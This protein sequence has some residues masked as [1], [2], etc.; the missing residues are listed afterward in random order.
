MRRVG[1]VGVVVEGASHHRAGPGD[2]IGQRRALEFVGF[3]PRFQILHFS[4][5]PLGDPVGEKAVLR[6]IGDTSNAAEI[7]ADFG[8]KTFEMVLQV[9]NDGHWWAR[10][11]YTG[12]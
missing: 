2:G 8:G 6:R 12:E 9:G 4:G 5:A 10:T 7:K 3:I 11:D 1:L